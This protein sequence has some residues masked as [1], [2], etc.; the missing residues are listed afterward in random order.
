MFKCTNYQN[1][2]F[3][4][5]KTVWTSSDGGKRSFRNWLRSFPG[6]LSLDNSL[7]LEEVGLEEVGLASE[8]DAGL[9]GAV[10]ERGV[11]LEDEE[12]R[13][14]TVMGDDTCLGDILFGM[15]TAT[16]SLSS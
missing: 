5:G 13:T 4:P 16:L 3:I 8:C 12:L 2:C 7:G 6:F 1:I 15:D 11:R 10:S 14:G 9:S